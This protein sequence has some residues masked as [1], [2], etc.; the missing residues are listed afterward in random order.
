LGAKKKLVVIDTN[1]FVID[2]RYQRDQKFDVNRQFLTGIATAGSG[3]TTTYNLLEVCGILSFNLNGQQLTELF[4]YFGQH[5][6]IRVMPVSDL[7]APLPFFT[8]NQIF[9]Q[10]CK[11]TALGDALILSTIDQYVPVADAIVSWDK[12][13]LA[14]KTGLPVL[15]PEEF[16]A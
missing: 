13:H 14:G 5:Y 2:L 10:I 11:K 7:Q 6:E 3:V 8:V 16:L 15:T 1:V 4:M 12:G 9:E